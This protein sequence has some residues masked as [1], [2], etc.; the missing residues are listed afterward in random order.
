MTQTQNGIVDTFVHVT[1]QYLTYPVNGLLQDRQAEGI[2]LTLIEAGPKALESPNDYDIRA[3]LM[4]CA[5]QA[6]N[7]LIGSGVPGDFAAHLIGHEITA[8]Y[9]LDHAKTLAVILPG[10]LKHQ[11][12]NKAA[13]LIQYAERVWGVNEGDDEAKIDA[14]IEKTAGF[15][16]SMGLATSFKDYDIGS[17][18]LERAGEQIEARG[19][20]LGEHKNIGRQEV[21]EILALCF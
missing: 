10:V 18:G 3:T 14:A 6:L 21:N 16:R 13:K 17:D 19:M 20:T 12:K 5:T 4:W 15:F 7:G 8:L 9:G 2:L 11:R 1:E